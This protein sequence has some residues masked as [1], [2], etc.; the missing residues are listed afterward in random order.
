MSKVV[1]PYKY[2]DEY[3]EEE[4]KI[5]PPLKAKNKKNWVYS[6]EINGWEFVARD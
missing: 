5:L 1:E 3:T 6:P 2:Y 4:L